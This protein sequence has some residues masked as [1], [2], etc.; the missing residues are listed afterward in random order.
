MEL[1]HFLRFTFNTNTNYPIRYP[2]TMGVNSLWKVLEEAGC[3][4]PVGA[5]DL[6]NPNHAKTN[7]FNFNDE[8]II[9]RQTLAIDLSIWICEALTQPHL[10]ESHAQPVVH[11]V[12]TRTLKLLHLGI[13]LVG[14]IEGKRRV[15]NTNEDDTFHK[16]RSGTSFWRACKACEELL[17]IMGVP[18]VKAKAEGEALCA[19][20]NQR[21]IV[22]GVISNDG[23][24]LLFGAKVIYTRFNMT[25]LADCQIIRYDAADLKAIANATDKK[26]DLHQVQEDGGNVPFDLSREDLISFALLTGSDLAGNGL[27]KV[28]H[29]KAIRFMFKCKQDNPLSPAT[30]AI[31]ELKS[32][33]RAAKVD[34]GVNPANTTAKERCCSVC[35]HSGNK[36]HHVKHGCEECGT[37]PGEPCLEFSGGDRFRKSLRKKALAAEP[38]FAPDQ[39]VASYMRPND[40][41]VPLALMNASSQTIRMRT[42]R[43]QDMMTSSFIVRGGSKHAS[44]GFVMETFGRLLARRDLCHDV[45]DPAR[46][47]RMS[48]SNECPV[49]IK[50]I[51]ECVKNGL[52][53]YEVSWF[54]TGTMTDPDGN[55][56]DGY[57]FNSM[58]SQSMF[59]K[60]PE[61][62]SSFNEAKKEEEKQGDAMIRKREAFKLS[63]LGKRKTID[64]DD[65]PKAADDKKRT[66][67]TRKPKN[68]TNFF[69]KHR[70]LKQPHEGRL[71]RATDQGQGE[72]VGMLLMA[73]GKGEK[74]AAAP[75]KPEKLSKN[76]ELPLKTREATR[77]GITRTDEALDDLSFDSMSAISLVSEL[78]IEAAQVVKHVEELNIRPPDVDDF[79]VK[80]MVIKVPR[81]SHPYY[82]PLMNALTSP[83]NVDDAET[84]ISTIFE[85][86]RG[87]VP[88]KKRMVPQSPG[89]YQQRG[90]HSGHAAQDDDINDW[91]S[92]VSHIMD[93]F[94][95]DR[96][97]ERYSKPHTNF[98]CD[99]FPPKALPSRRQVDH[100]GDTIEFV[101][102]RI[103]SPKTPSQAFLDFDHLRIGDSLPVFSGS[104]RMYNA[105]TPS[106]ESFTIALPYQTPFA[107]K[108]A[109][110][111]L[112][113]SGPLFVNLGM[114]INV[115][116]L[117]RSIAHLG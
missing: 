20:L 29:R 100:L 101:P 89:A 85:E 11:L 81:T 53:C 27:D 37:S 80:N 30:A 41:Q 55:D 114:H 74:S 78:K 96:I 86:Y 5:K 45:K 57:Q 59:K 14:V 84:A 68:Q 3:G 7:P 32:W 43:L 107:D 61:I 112:A 67:K 82:A 98:Y 115:S 94:R 25:N 16:R 83:N 31:D 73:L 4:R 49:P 22:D 6:L 111:E 17:E 8:P 12:Y 69:E 2:F 65:L 105:N 9:K 87:V 116:P 110:A 35:C 113:R 99:M 103:T 51:R 39:T 92:V 91:K 104:N 54:V 95:F 18:V 48:L 64:D 117:V 33:A 19:L 71:V 36:K 60:Y 77:K 63:L 62:I 109:L 10:V 97:D 28:G 88:F 50:I 108:S 75:T 46:S 38:R 24:C 34:G 13:K 21:G 66:K 76:Q 102:Q 106:R 56:I 26:T 15:M 58:E 90:V 42:P 1:P 72:D 40:N 44:N 52:K 79:T 70:A 47:N 93:E 23:D